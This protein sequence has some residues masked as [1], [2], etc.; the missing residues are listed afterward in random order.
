[1]TPQGTTIQEL[2]GLFPGLPGEVYFPADAV[3]SGD[4]RLA[5]RS[6]A[7]MKAKRKDTPALA[8][9]RAYHTAILEPQAFAERYVVMPSFD[10]RTNVGK[11]AYGQWMRENEGKET[12]AQDDLEAVQRMA[13]VV[14]RHPAARWIFGAPGQRELSGFWTDPLTGVPCKMRL[15]FLR[16]DDLVADPKTTQDASP[17]GFRRAVEQ[18]DY[19]LQEAHYRAGLEV[20]GRPCR[21]WVWVAQEVEPPYAVGVYTL[22]PA[23]VQ[24]AAD[25]RARALEAIAKARATG[26]WR[27]YSDEV[28]PINLS[29]WKYRAATENA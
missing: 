5:R 23:A 12:I 26:E 8:F 1:M 7:H 29:A 10:R 2:Q 25:E 21:G 17:H 27:A 6:L 18:Y 20:L 15:D 14:L 16:D 11:A 3:G 13:E 19:H 24:L 28:V 9:G 22:D 4:V